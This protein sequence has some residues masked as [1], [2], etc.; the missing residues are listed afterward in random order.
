MPGVL[1]NDINAFLRATARAIP[2]DTLDPKCPVAVA[3]NERMQRLASAGQRVELAKMLNDILYDDVVFETN[4]AF[5]T[6][7]TRATY[8]SLWTRFCAWC[9]EAGLSALPADPETVCHFLIEET[10][11]SRPE[12]LV[13]MT[14]AIRFYHE[15]ADK[16]YSGDDVLIRAALRRARRLY[17]QQ[18]DQDNQTEPEPPANPEPPAKH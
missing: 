14:S 5:G 3:I 9:E 6:E 16:P 17:E 12:Q 15:W 8:K 7:G 18:R 13:K 11:N 1:P 2:G 10:P 4:R